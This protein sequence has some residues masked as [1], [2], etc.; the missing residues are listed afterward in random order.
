MATAIGPDARVIPG[1][2]EGLQQ[3]SVGDEAVIF[4]PSH[5]AYGPGGAGNVIPPNTDLIFVLEMTGI[6]E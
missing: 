4:I 1:F 3:M 6:K 2:K 5:L